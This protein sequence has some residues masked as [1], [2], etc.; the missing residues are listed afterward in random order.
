MPTA[1]PFKALGRG[2]GFPYCGTKIDVN[3]R[4][5]G[6]AY[7]RYKVLTLAEAMKLYWNL[8]SV[9][10]SASA[11]RDGGGSLNA[12]VSSS[13]LKQPRLRV[14]S[15]EFFWD[16]DGDGFSSVLAT[17]AIPDVYRLYDG[18][19][20]DE[21]NFLGYT[22]GAIAYASVDYVLTQFIDVIYTGLQAYD[23]GTSGEPFTVS[24]V[25]VDGVT[26]FQLRAED[27]GGDPPQ[28]SA[29]ITGTDSYTY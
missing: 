26:L 18:S 4:G 10:A 17:V 14:C 23:G 13:V 12:S 16:D 25:T 9:Y 11:P 22:V 28:I 20:S 19:T 2:N 5:D 24:D 7:F 8:A 15:G 29:S 6:N 3:N 21:T 27:F 1:T